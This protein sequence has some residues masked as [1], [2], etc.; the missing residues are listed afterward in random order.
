M[1]K[2]TYR[3]RERPHRLGTALFVGFGALA[4]AATPWRSG[5]SLRANAVC[6]L[7]A[8]LALWVEGVANA[9]H[10]LAYGLLVLL[11]AAALRRPLLACLL[12]FA[13]SAMVEL[14]QS[15]FAVG[16]CRLRDMLPNLLALGL[17]GCV[18]RAFR[19]LVST[20]GVPES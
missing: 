19:W 20:L 5:F 1:T 11:G 14:E 13:L 15:V 2:P 4:L 10:L 8:P 16:H 3:A 17:A 9:Q 6:E 18:M 7:R 12:V